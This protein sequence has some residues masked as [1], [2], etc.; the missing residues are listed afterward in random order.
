MTDKEKG[1]REGPFSLKCLSE[2]NLYM[3]SDLFLPIIDSET[4][5][6]DAMGQIDKANESL[7]SW[8]KERGWVGK[9]EHNK[10]VQRASALANELRD[11]TTKSD[12][13]KSIAQ[14]LGEKANSV[15][16]LCDYGN[17][18]T[19]PPGFWNEKIAGLRAALSRLEKAGKG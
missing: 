14:E 7:F 19:S 8:L 15:L 6:L 5:W 16:P 1:E 13:W 18:E 2:T 9:E 3:D 4:T 11:E 17:M 10:A 12:L